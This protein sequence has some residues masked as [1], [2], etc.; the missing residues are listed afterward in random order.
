MTHARSGGLAIGARVQFDGAAL[1]VTGITGS[2]VLLTDVAGRTV[3]VEMGEVCGPRAVFEASGMPR[4]SV[5]ADL[6]PGVPAEAAEQ[7]RW[8]EHHVLEVMTGRPAEP[9]TQAR[10]AYDPACSTLA[11]REAAKARELTAAGH[12]GITARRINRKRLRYQAEGLAGLVDRRSDRNS[13]IG[14]RLDGRVVEAARR[15]IAE[16]AMSSTRTIG[17]LR[18]RAEQILIAEHGPG[19]VAMPSRAAFY[20]LH[21]RLAQGTH[22]TGSARTRRSIAARTETPYGVFAPVRPG[23]LMQIDSTPLDVAVLLDDGVAGRVELTG[24]ID[25]ATRTVT[26]AVLRP[27]TKAVDASLLLARTVTPEPMR[28]GWPE[29]LRM[30]SSVLPYRR[31]LELD[32]RL[33]RAAARPVIIPETI[34]CDQ[35]KVFVS[36]AFRA[37]CRTLGIDLQPAHDASPAEKPHIEKMMFSVGTLFAQY[38]AGYLGSSVERRGKAPERDR[39]WSLPE[40]QNLLDEWLITWQN[41]EHDGLRDPS[42]PRRCFTPNEKYA[43]LI[44]ACGYIPLALSADDYVELLPAAWRAINHY[45]VKIGHRT[46]DAEELN[47]LRRQRSGLAERKHLWEVHHVL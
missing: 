27:S 8:W 37:A 40:L 43:A 11:E 19:T 45:G 42:C 16:T 12:A 44:E 26:A 24:M 30:A 20:R 38:V 33:E 29:A 14:A 34:V 23:E 3:P 41:R 47:P 46:Y 36:N 39:L 35:G 25:V 28:P 4:F 5:S 32:E 1:T 17:Y 7:A 10:A 22:A 2:S 15:A 6:L 31:M 18:W 13:P 21:D 9:G